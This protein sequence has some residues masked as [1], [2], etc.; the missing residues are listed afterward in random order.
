VVSVLLSAGALVEA[1]DRVRALLDDE[2]VSKS[3]NSL[4]IRKTPLQIACQQGHVEVVSV[5]LSAGAVVD[6]RHDVCA[7]CDDDVHE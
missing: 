2:T 7:V 1:R 3:L 6:S 5:L 4:Q